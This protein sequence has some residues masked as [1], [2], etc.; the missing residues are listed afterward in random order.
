MAARRIWKL[1]LQIIDLK[2]IRVA[3]SEPFDEA[4]FNMKVSQLQAELEDPFLK[5]TIVY[6]HDLGLRTFAQ[7]LDRLVSLNPSTPYL[8]RFYPEAMHGEIFDR[9][10]RAQMNACES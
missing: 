2:K 4:L 9:W 5:D 3:A 10:L 1:K 8:I 6:V 7:I